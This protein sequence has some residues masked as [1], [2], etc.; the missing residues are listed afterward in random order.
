M[1]N[2]KLNDHKVETVPPVMADACRHYRDAT[3][4]KVGKR[5]GITQE[6]WREHQS[7]KMWSKIAMGGTLGLFC[8]PA[9]AGWGGVGM[10]MGGGGVG[11]SVLEVA[12]VGSG[13]GALGGNALHNPERADGSKLGKIKLMDM[14][15]VI[16]KID[17]RWTDGGYDVQV[18][19]MTKDD[20]GDW[21]VAFTLWHNPMELYGLIKA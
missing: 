21:A 10:V 2:Y 8:L 5:V 15:G 13:V 9:L 17:K 16:R 19:W 7:H 1:A 18:A 11:I 4:L 14:I 20:Y 12:A 3:H 6:G